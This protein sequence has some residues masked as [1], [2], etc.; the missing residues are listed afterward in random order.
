[1]NCAFYAVH[2]PKA[3]KTGLEKA[4]EFTVPSNGRLLSEQARNVTEQSL[5]S[6]G[7][8][9]DQSSKRRPGSYRW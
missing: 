3:A 8:R 5:Y 2:R 1:M 4:S 6:T 7:K 9:P